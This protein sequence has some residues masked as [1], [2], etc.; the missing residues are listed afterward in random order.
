MNCSDWRLDISAFLDGNL[1]L[2]RS[3]ALEQHLV[4]C[5]E[6]SSFLAEQKELDLTFQTALPNLEPPTRIWQG[7]EARL[8]SQPK[9]RFWDF[10]DLLRM[11]RLG[12]AGAALVVILMFGLLIF[13]KPD[14]VGEE[15]RYLAELEAFSIEVKGNPFLADVQTENPFMKLGK[16]GSGNPFQ[17]LGGSQ[18]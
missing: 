15:A 17:Q 9:P 1:E 2:S 14:S 16:F 13:D 10:S 3:D 5:V 11:P 7:I 6:C 8:V 12:Y 18:Q 4:E